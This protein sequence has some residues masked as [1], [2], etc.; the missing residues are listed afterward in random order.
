MF[1]PLVT[2]ARDPGLR[3]PSLLLVL[4]GAY[5]SSLAPYQSLLA[6]EHF[7]L[8]NSAYSLVLIAG[9]LVFVTGSVTLGI[10]SDQWLSRRAVAYVATLCLIAGPALLVV[11][12]APWSF[13]LAHM[14]MVPL[15]GTIF[16]QGFALARLA[17]ERHPP[18]DRPGL[19][20]AVRALFAVP[21]VV[22]LPLWS[23]AFHAGAGVMRI[24]PVV[25]LVAVAML[26]LVR[27][28]W[29]TGPAAG[30]EG[31]KSRQSFTAALAEFRAPGLILRVALLGAVNCA[32][33]LYMVL[34]GLVFAN[35]GRPEGDV[36]LYVGMVAGAE[37]PFMLL[38][39]R[40]QIHRRPAPLIAVGVG[41][42]CIHL[43]LMAPL[44]GTVFVWCLVLPAALGGAAVLTLPIVYLQDM[45]AARPGAGASLMAFQRVMGDGLSAVAFALGTATAGYGTAALIG[46]VI[47]VGAGLVLWRLDNR[48]QTVG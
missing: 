43:A 3:L 14:L 46:T 45:M 40:L 12:P 19:M 10:L 47:A 21:F 20:A 35:A 39:P 22:V 36:A 32:V 25:M 29:P 38:L 9:A 18:A 5:A 37:V 8:T 11:W 2:L 26:G 17:T 6:I 44:A 16:A 1:Q 30:L 34:V 28:G 23:L 13:A 31:P 33:T 41:I 48:S 4:Y 42:Y 15:G 7:G 24:Y 27:W